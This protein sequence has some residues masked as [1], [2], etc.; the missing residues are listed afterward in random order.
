MA[1]SVILISSNSSEDSMGTPAGR[2]ILFGTIPT[3]IPDTTPVIA[4]PTTEIPIVAPTIPPSPDY[5][6]ASEAESDPSEHLASGHISPL[7]AISPFLSSDDDTTNTPGQPIPH[8]R[9]Y[10]YHPNGPVHMMNA[11]KRV[12]PLLVQQLLVR[13]SVD[14]S[15]SDSSSRHSSSDHSSPDLPST[16][17]GPSRKRRRSLLTSIPTL[18]LVSEALSPVHVDLIQPPK[19]VRDIIYL[20]DVEVDPSE[21][22]V[23]RVTHPAMLEDI[24]EPAQ[25]GAAEVMYKTLGDLV[26]RFHDHAQAVPVYRVQ[27]IEG[28]QREQGHRIVRVKSAVTAL[29]E[30]VAE[31]ERDNQRLRGTASVESLRVDRLQRDMSRMQREM[32]K[33]PNTR[34]RASMTHEEVEELVTRRVAEEMEARE[35][36]RS[37]KTLNENE[38][39]Q[40]GNGNHGMNYGSFIP[41]AQECTFQ[42]FLKCKP[43][44]FSG[45]EGVVELTRWFKKIETV[46]NISNCPPKYRVKYATCT[47]Q[48]NALTWWNSHKRTIG[49]DAAYAMNWAGLMKLMT[50]VYCLRNELMDKKLQGDAARSDENKRRMESNLRDNY[51]EQPPFKRQNTTGQNVARAYTAGNNER[52][53]LGIV[54]LLLTQTLREPQGIVCYECGRPRHFRKDCPKLRNQNCGNQTRNKTGGNEVTATA[55]AIGRGG[56]NPDSK[57]VTGTLLLNSCYASMLFDSGADR[58][59]VSTTFSALLDVAPSTLDTSYAVKLTDGRISETNIIIR[60]CT[61]GLLGHPFNIDLMPI[62]LGSFDVIIGMDWLAKYHVLIVCDEKVVC[63]PYGDEVLIIRG[64]N[65]NGGSKLNII[66]CTKTQKYI[67]KGCQVYLTQVTSKKAEDK[68]K[69]KRL[70][71][72]PIVQEFPEVFPED[73]PGLPPTRQTQFLTMGAPVLFVKKKDGSFRMYIDYR[74]LNKLTV[75][76]RYPLLRIDDVFDQLQ[77][78]RVYSKIDLRSGYHQ[79]RVR[80]EDIPK[81]AFRTCYGHYDFQVMS[82]GLTNVPAVFMDLMNREEELYAKFSKFEFWLSKVQFLG[83]VVDSEGIYVDPVKIEAIKGSFSKIA[84]PM[85]KWTQKSV[86]FDWGEKAEAAFLLLKQKLCSAPILALPEGSENFVNFHTTTVTH[87]SIK[88]ALFEALYGR[89]CRLPIRWA[90]VGDRQL[91]GPEIIHETTEKIF[92]IKSR[93]QAACDRQKSYANVRRKPLKFQVGDKVMLKVSPWKRVIRF[94][95]RGKLNP[96]YIGPFKILAKV[97]TV[98]YRLELPEQLSRVYITFY[99]SKLKKCMADELLAIPLDE[100]QVDNKL[101]FIEEPVE[102][103]DREVKR[104]K[105]SHVPIVKVC[106]NSKRGPE[107][108]WEREDQMQKKYPHLFPSSAPM[109]DNTSGLDLTYAPSTITTQQPSE[110]E[111]ALL[112]EAMYNDYIGG[113]SSATARTVLAVQEPKVR[114]TSTT[115]TSIAD[116]VPTPTN[117][118]SHVTNIP[119]TAQ[120]V[121]ELNP[122]AM[123]DGNTTNGYSKQVSSC[124]ERVPPRGRNQFRRILLVARMEAITIFLAYAAHKLFLVFQMDVKTAFLHGS[125]KEDVYVCQPEGFIDADHPGHVYKLKKALYGL[126][127]APRAWYDKLS[128]F[129]LQNHFFKG[130]I[131]P[132]LF[133]R[134]FIDDILVVQVYVDDIIFGST[135]P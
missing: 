99:V 55:Y 41:M 116:T 112:I 66:S 98:A 135:H 126:K 128:T 12:R 70:E 11:R 84:R 75:K 108:T 22:R 86:K 76:N 131:D 25:E 45:T 27:T 36:A 130:T 9:P 119:I 69:E 19:R 26:Q 28:V 104:L 3:T 85:T 29:T 68:S 56:T 95:K 58:S 53:G 127:Q 21:T 7:P 87:T 2:V 117:S 42:D 82:F 15:S 74:E 44:T 102:I 37:L 16:S 81:T 52:K 123:I 120:D 13:H 107:F 67:Q 35:A 39:E 94:S 73:L 64:D 113:Q 60:G 34:S 121:N 57:V 71:D 83:H 125:L 30:R 129:P 77:G 103:M 110:G 5:S 49:V 65:C 78:S 133:I 18:P 91:T 51:G 31:L 61:L 118:S 32:R 48:N 72:V 114:Q 4:P 54:G 46:F 6:P 97:G 109:T 105:Q 33:M 89:K 14:H 90:K 17:A 1:T 40:E 59:F 62:E 124:R 38:E 23:E 132:M 10:R 88:A 122:N 63:I 96:R 106:W 8:G 47:L 115:S 20:A 100:I 80:E 43:H 101:N 111:L 93:I 92:Q 79:L 50:K 24:P 134:R